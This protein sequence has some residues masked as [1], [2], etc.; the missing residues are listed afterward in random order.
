MVVDG[1]VHGKDNFEELYLAAVGPG[2]QRFSFLTILPHEQ[3]VNKMFLARW[4]ERLT[5]EDD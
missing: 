5:I 1:T 3:D 2:T 4:D